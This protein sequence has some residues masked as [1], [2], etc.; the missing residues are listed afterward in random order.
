MDVCDHKIERK[1]AVSEV[2]KKLRNYAIAREIVIDDKFRNENGISLQMSCLEYAYTGGQSGLNRAGGWFQDIVK[3]YTDDRDNFETL[4][5]E[6]NGMAEQAS[7]DKK[8]FR[9]WLEESEPEENAT[10]LASLTML[11]V[12]LR[13][14]G[15]IRSHLLDIDDVDIIEKLVDD[16]KKNKG[17]R[18][19][20]KKRRNLVLRGLYAYKNFLESEQSEE[21]QFSDDDKNVIGVEANADG[22]SDKKS[23]VLTASF[24]EKRDYS[25]TRPLS[26]S[27]FGTTYITKN[28]SALYVQSVNCLL[29][30]YPNEIHA[31]IG[32][33]IGGRVRVDISEANGISDMEA[34]KKLNDNLYLETN[35]SAVGI[36]GKI[37]Q[38]MDICR[39]DYSAIRIEYEHKGSDKGTK[40]SLEKQTGRS[41]G[42][43]KSNG[44]FYIW[45]TEKEGLAQ[46]TGRRY[47]S[48]I[49]NCDAFC[50]EY[51][52][53]TGKLYD[54]DSVD[55]ISS[56][57]DL[58][59]ENEKFQENNIA[60][61]NRFT[62]ALTKYKQY[63]GI[64]DTVPSRRKNSDTLPFEDTDIALEELARIRAT[65]ELSR[66]NYGFKDNDDVELYRFRAFYAETNGVECSLEKEELLRA[67]RS[68]GFEFEGKIYLISE[69][70]MNDIE[71]EMRNYANEGINIIYY[72]ELYDLRSDEYFD[73]KI[74]S[75]EMLRVILKQLLPEFRYKNNYLAL[76]K[77]KL[78]EIELTKNDIIRVWGDGVLQTFDELSLKLPL[79]PL[80]KVKFTLAHQPLF[81]WNSAET[82]LQ[83][84]SFEVDED[85]INRLIE[86][87]DEQCEEH[88]SASL[89]EMPFENLK[90]HNPELSE[91][92]IINCFCRLVDDRFD[93][94]ARI[95]T[96]KG[97]GKDTCTVVIEFCRKQ[98][99]CTYDRLV[100]IA[101]KVAGTVRTPEV[102]EAAN[103]VMVRIDKDS[104]IADRLISFDVDRVDAALDHIVTNEFM[105]MKEITTFSTLPFCGYGWNLF[106]LESYCRR[107]SKKYRYATRRANSSNS[108][109]VVARTCGL[110]YH[111]IMAEALARS[112]RELIEDEVFAFLT[113]AGYMER[114]RYSDIERLITY[115]KELRERR[116]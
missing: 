59:M 13:K 114:K 104:F 16:I 94:N 14:N 39:V 21:N 5:Q 86:F 107:F 64:T 8:D 67:I 113:D 11:D 89:N 84:D 95:L 70:T 47:A 66:Y 80:D 19:H 90:A 58:L 63:L 37:R 82:Y 52:I 34:P 50:R 15:A 60:G 57:I 99:K 18:I 29:A 74:V 98:E 83:E 20:S 62:A 12:L 81:V 31:L 4:L 26:V 92:A 3:M 22:V 88:G 38:L 10:I 116:K 97:A 93:R 2:S 111:D 7:E 24:T 51:H 30:D 43:P 27:Y 79:I 87:I 106:L 23:D 68:M 40:N 6:V 61:H 1:Q 101:E 44:D 77:E 17:A 54:A 109:A 110:S 65:L 33:N 100:H 49:N 9:S 102:I 78:T 41:A 105:G 76:A 46:P 73:A 91:T 35:C 32:K 56:N 55:E 25:Y 75:A 53:G 48:A 96:R 42:A 115:A 112:G 71:T 69:E 28:W 45:L 36:I 108:G 72:E 103:S 85:E